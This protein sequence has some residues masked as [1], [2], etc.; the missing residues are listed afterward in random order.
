MSPQPIGGRTRFLGHGERGAE[1]VRNILERLR[2]SRRVVDYVS[3]MVREHLRPG[4]ISLGRELPSKRAVFRYYRDLGNT[5]KD[6]VFLSLSD[7]LAARG[8]RLEAE[9]WQGFCGVADVILNP[10]F[11]PEDS[12]ASLLLNG[13]Q[14]Q[15]HFGLRPGPVIG[16]LEP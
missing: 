15:R 7:Y 6:T 1:I 5:G 9:D 3:V 12:K 4:Q 16:H 11:D 13:N 8:P 10:A 14:L 2:C